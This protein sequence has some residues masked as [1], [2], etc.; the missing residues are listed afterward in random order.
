[1]ASI[2]VANKLIHTV[3][4]SLF[5]KAT[6]N[7]GVLLGSISKFFIESA[8]LK[9][10]CVLYSAVIGIPTY[11]LLLKNYD[12]IASILGVGGGITSLAFACM[13]TF[14]PLIAG[15]RVRGAIKNKNIHIIQLL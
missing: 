4:P 15:F 11:S 13:G 5:V 10:E 7:E 8:L 6:T 12:E 1:M 14:A 2:Y 9:T 3:K